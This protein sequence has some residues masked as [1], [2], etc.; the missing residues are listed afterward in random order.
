[1]DLE[2][3]R[4]VGKIKSSYFVMLLPLTIKCLKNLAVLSRQ[5]RTSAKL[6]IFSAYSYLGIIILSY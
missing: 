2:P 5:A 1:M 4:I 3:I 6:T